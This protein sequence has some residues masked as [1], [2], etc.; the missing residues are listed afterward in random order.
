MSN[1]RPERL[2]QN[3]VAT[4]FIHSAEQGG[5]IPAAMAKP[6]NASVLMET[7]DSSGDGHEESGNH[8]H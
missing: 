7:A 5:L 2:A 8:E 6:V 3:R 4:L 1:P